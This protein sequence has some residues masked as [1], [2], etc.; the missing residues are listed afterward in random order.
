M[1][2]NMK[3]KTNIVR[4]ELDKLRKEWGY[5]PSEMIACMKSPGNSS[6]GSE[7]ERETCKKLGLWWTHGERD[8]IFW[9]TAGS[10]ARATVRGRKGNTTAGQNG[11][12]AATD[13]LGKPLIDA[14]TIELKRGY[15]ERTIQDLLDKSNKAANQEYEKFILQTIESWEQAGSKSWIL[16]VRRN[17]REALIF[18]PYLAVKQ[19][20]VIGCFPNG[21]PPKSVVLKT[22]LRYKENNLKLTVCGMQLNDWLDAVTPGSILQFLK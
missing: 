20:K 7:Y 1:V 16:I 6:K 5:S 9:R 15:S 14:F 12:I 22:L 3:P 2:N 11:D 18:L 21:L 4:K 10:G 8:D 17:R 19:L 13:P